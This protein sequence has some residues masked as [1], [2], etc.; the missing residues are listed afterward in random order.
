MIENVFSGS[1]WFPVATYTPYV[2]AR[3]NLGAS[4]MEKVAKDSDNN[5]FLSQL[6]S[7]VLLDISLS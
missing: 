1:R 2:A 7:V 4:H 3:M 5:F 6:I